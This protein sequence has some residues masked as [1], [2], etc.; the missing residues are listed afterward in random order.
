MIDQ[1]RK[2]LL[3]VDAIMYQ[4]WQMSRSEERGLLARVKQGAGKNHPESHGEVGPILPDL[5]AGC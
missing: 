4:R 5:K 3:I 2:I 1:T